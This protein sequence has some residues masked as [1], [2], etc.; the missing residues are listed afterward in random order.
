MENRDIKTLIVDDQFP[1]RNVI[2]RILQPY[3]QCTMAR[4]GQEA[5]DYFKKAFDKNKPYDLICLDIMMPILDGQSVLEEIRMYED[6]HSIAEENR[7]KIIMISALRDRD[8][9]AKALQAHCDA[10]IIKPFDKEKLLATIMS[11][12]IPISDEPDE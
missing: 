10:Y 11:L 9:V 12:D 7:T 1:V 6:L 5:L 2:F 8:D 3:M 4:E